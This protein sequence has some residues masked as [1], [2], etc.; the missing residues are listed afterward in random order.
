VY[1][2]Y[3]PQDEEFHGAQARNYN[4]RP[5]FWSSKS[6]VD[7]ERLQLKPGQR[8]LDVGCG[9]GVDLQ[10]LFARYG[11]GVNLYGVDPS[12][13]MLKQVPEGFAK[14]KN[15]HLDRATALELPY[16]SSY[17]DFVTCSLV[18]HHLQEADQQKALQEMRRVLKP[19]G[20]VL[21]K[22]WGRPRNVFGR[23]IA[24]LWHNHAYVSKS[25]SKD[26]L[27]A[28]RQ[29]GFKQVEIVSIKRGIMYQ[30]AA[31]K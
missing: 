10:K 21:I 2:L 30:L 20:V 4:K 24:W 22:D 23:F 15:V 31:T 27:M 11:N 16:S 1:P 12:E 26:W 18:L 14:N 25:A 6:L 29:A 13:D 5:S 28:L 3:V 17:F 9:T 19:G 7:S 8:L